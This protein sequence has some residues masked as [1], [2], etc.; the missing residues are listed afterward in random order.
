MFLP[1]N[2]CYYYYYFFFFGYTLSEKNRPDI[3]KFIW[4]LQ[5]IDDEEKHLGLCHIFTN[6]Q[7]SMDC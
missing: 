6:S 2:Y 3:D 1:Q 4:V 5:C 7:C